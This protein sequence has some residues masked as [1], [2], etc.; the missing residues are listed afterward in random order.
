MPIQNLCKT[1]GAFRYKQK[2]GV[3]CN[4]E[5]LL[6]R[7][8]SYWSYKY[9]GLLVLVQPVLLGPMSPTFIRQ[10]YF[11]FVNEIHDSKH[12]QTVVNI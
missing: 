12:Y 9:L 6:S 8:I 11:N 3:M 2:V 7:Y 1:G 10:F 4:G 5:I